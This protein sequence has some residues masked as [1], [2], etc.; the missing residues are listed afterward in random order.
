MPI[1][2][3]D[4][5]AKGEKGKAKKTV[6]KILSIVALIQLSIFT[7]NSMAECDLDLTVPVYDGQTWTERCDVQVNGVV[8]PDP[9]GCTKVVRIAW[10]WG[11]GVV[12]DSWFPAQHT[13]DADSTPKCIT[14]MRP[15]PRDN[16]ALNPQV[17]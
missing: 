10:D 3:I 9:P 6:R 13:Y 2:D 8:V 11:D 12:G 1:Y 14:P 17:F 7:Q 15:V 5:R 4:I 16:C